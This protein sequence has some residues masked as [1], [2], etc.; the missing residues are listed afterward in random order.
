[1]AKTNKKPQIIGISGTFASGKDALA[2]CLERDHGYNHVSLGNMVR[3]VAK[4]LHG[5]VERPILKQVAENLRYEKGAGALVLEALKEPRP[6]VIT[7]VRTIG[8]AKAL[9][10]AG[11]VILF[12]DT[13]IEVRF[14][15]VKTRMRDRETELTLDEFS[16]NEEKEMYSGPNDEDF[17]IRGVGKLADIHI[18]SGLPLEDYAQLAYHKLGLV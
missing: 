16:K 5:S 6:L 8:E 10:E 15:R 13:D 7:G 12:V 3:K 14:I 4:E 18:D 2:E 11:A 17:N 9:Q 1:M